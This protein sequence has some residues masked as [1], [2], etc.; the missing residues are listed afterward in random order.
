MIS[1]ASTLAARLAENAEDVCRHYLSEGRRRGRHWQVGDVSNTPGRSLYV[2]LFGPSFGPGA[3]GKWADAAT[4]E[5]GDLLD[6]IRLNR[7][8]FRL[9]DTLDEAR[10]FLQEPS[11]V[12]APARGAAPRNSVESARRLFA[13][14]RPIA[15][16]L[17]EVYLRKR[18]ITLPLRFPSLRFHPDCY[19]RA[20]EDSPLETWP[21]LIASATDL[22]GTITGVH[23]TWLARDGSGKAG[24]ADPR[25]SMGRILGHAVRFGA[26]SDVLAATE[27]IETALALKCLLP[28]LPVAA[29]LS[30]SN[31][32]GLL[33]PEGLRRLYI[34]ADNDAAGVAALE[35]LKARAD[36]AC[37]EA[38]PLLP[39]FEDWNEDLVEAGPKDSFRTAAG[40]LLIEDVERFAG[41]PLSR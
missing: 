23:R 31:L 25:R 39:C 17:A 5:H 34:A 40:Q 35:R 6:L 16:S 20:D 36:A 3:A 15:G 10:D 22:S 32:G 29:A 18:G 4:G 41:P 2:R 27:G 14:S 24:I 37:V 21:A 33:F 13:A 30:A 19:Y 38:H 28:G 11:R 7:G 12:A 26:A 8:H 1:E 9:R